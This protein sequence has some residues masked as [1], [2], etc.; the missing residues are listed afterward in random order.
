MQVVMVISMLTAMNI[1]NEIY[2]YCTKS[3]HTKLNLY[4]HLLGLYSSQ[5][6]LSTVDG[7]QYLQY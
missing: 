5:D 6:K 7:M 2:R 4:D 3:I 1:S